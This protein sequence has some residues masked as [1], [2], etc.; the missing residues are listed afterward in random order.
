MGVIKIKK[1]LNL[2]IN[3]EPKNFIDSTKKVSKVGILGSDF[4]GLKPTFSVAVGEKVKLGQLLF[5]DKKVEGIKFTSPASGTITE[6]NRGDK[7]VFLSLVIDIEGNDEVVFKNY[8]ETQIPSLTRDEVKD[9]LIESGLW[10]SLRERPMS[11]IANP[12]IVPNSIFITAMDSNP[13]APNV[14]F[15]LKGKENSFKNGLRVLSKLTDGTLFLCKDENSEIPSVQLPNLTEQEFSGIHPKGLAGTHIHFLDPVSRTKKVW[16]INAQDVA[17][18]GNLFTTGKIDTER[19]ISLVGPSVNNPRYIKTRIGASISEICNNEL[20]EKRNRTISGSV[21]SGKST[22]KEENYLGRYH[23]QISVIEE[24]NNRDFLGWMNPA[25]NLFSVK[26]VL[27]S[28][29]SSSRKYDFSTSLNGGERAIVPIGSYEKV[30]PLDILPTFLL[31]SL[32]V[33]DI[34]DSEK[35][36]CLELDEEDLALCTFVCPSK[37]DHGQNL[38]RNLNLIDKEG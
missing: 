13:L 30:M 19:I 23:Q 18:I 3:G 24:H 32:A 28:S 34:E 37:I 25:K 11:K 31:R 10:I 27:F 22:N 1:G 14:S 8:S 2:P 15:I 20:N 12:S 6:I 7:R 17:A 16:Y 35:L 5:A 29:L 38:R 36:G 26:N 21:L 9:Q 33:D 4:N